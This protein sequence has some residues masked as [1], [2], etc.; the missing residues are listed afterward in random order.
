MYSVTTVLP[1]SRTD[2]PNQVSSF[3]I[4]VKNMLSSIR[5]FKERRT[6]GVSNVYRRYFVKNEFS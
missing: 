1:E 2:L 3:S 4:K 5:N 6:K